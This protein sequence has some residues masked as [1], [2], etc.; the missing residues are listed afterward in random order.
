MNLCY[1]FTKE[2][3]FFMKIIY[4]IFQIEKGQSEFTPKEHSYWLILSGN[5]QISSNN[6]TFFLSSHDIL[7]IPPNQT[8]HVSCYENMQ[9]GLM[10]LPGFLSP[11]T[12]LQHKKYDDTE[13]IRKI[14]FFALDFQGFHHEAVP[15]M[16]YHINNLMYTALCKTGLRD[17]RINPQIAHALNEL[18]KHYLEPDYDFNAV[19][20]ASSYSTS[21]FH[22]LFHE[23]TGASPI[24]WIHIHRIEHAK[25]LLKQPQKT[26][27]KEIAL[28]CGYTDA[29]YFSRV[30]RK[31][32]GMSPSEYALK[33]GDL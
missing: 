5:G 1:N 20:A 6:C 29:Y 26:S 27:I 14:F 4:S 32:T 19:I 30:F 18:N 22:K 8:C 12:L 24:G 11:N 7:E 31:Q 28:A 16:M 13:I 9:I 21:H 2:R 23:T 15:N 25:Y 33:A 10:S 17:Y 3:W